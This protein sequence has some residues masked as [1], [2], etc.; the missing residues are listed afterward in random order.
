MKAPTSSELRERVDAALSEVTLAEKALEKALKELAS[1]R[2][3]EK[4]AVSA[5]VSDA[6]TRLRA[7]HAELLRLRELVSDT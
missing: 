1:G 7:A 4:V 6:F 3:A 5:V 2:R